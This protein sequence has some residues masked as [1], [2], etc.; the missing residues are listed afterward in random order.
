MAACKGYL[1]LQASGRA[2]G[3]PAS[4]QSGRARGRSGHRSGVV[5]RDLEY[6]ARAAAW[7]MRFAEAAKDQTHTGTQLLIHRRETGLDC[8]RHEAA[9]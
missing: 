5:K 7:M 9:M 2:R 8:D 6:V 3:R 1:H 4:R